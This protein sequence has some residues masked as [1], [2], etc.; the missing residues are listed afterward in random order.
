MSLPATTSN[1]ENAKIIGLNPIMMK[2]NIAM[3]I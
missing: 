3:A 1:I 2:F